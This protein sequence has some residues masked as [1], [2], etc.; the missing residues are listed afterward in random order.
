MAHPKTSASAGEVSFWPYPVVHLRIK[1]RARRS[2]SSSKAAVM[3]CRPWTSR[4]C[5]LRTFA[6]FVVLA[7]DARHLITTSALSMID[8][9]MVIPR[10][11]AVLRFTTSRNVVGRSTGSSAGLLPLRTLATITAIRS[12]SKSM[13]GP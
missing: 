8:F 11:L 2:A 10:V 1:D 4:V 3:L 6:A 12:P 13:S 9:G 7:I 5:P